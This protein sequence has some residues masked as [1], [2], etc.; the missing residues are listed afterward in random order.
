MLELFPG[1]GTAT[2]QLLSARII[3]TCPCQ[4]CRTSCHI[5]RQCTIVDKQGTYFTHSL[6]QL[7]LGLLQCN[8][9][10]S[11]IKLDQRLTGLYQFGIV[12]MDGH[13]RATDLRC[14]LHYI[15]SNIGVISIFEMTGLDSP[16]DTVTNQKNEEKN[17]HRNQ[18]ALAL[19]VAGRSFRHDGLR[20]V[21]ICCRI[22]DA[23]LTK[24]NLLKLA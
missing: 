20:R 21:V 9:C 23:F 15:A 2:V 5:C 12:C 19:T 24:W 22:H 7:R 14:N 16:P 4:L 6:R 10:I 1:Y 17:R 13:Y 3:G 11:A 8:L 18:A